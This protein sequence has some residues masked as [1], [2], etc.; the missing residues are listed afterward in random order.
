MALSP[1]LII[2]I[3][4][5]IIIIIS[6]TFSLVAVCLKALSIKQCTFSEFKFD[7]FICAAPFVQPISHWSL[8]F[9]VCVRYAR[10]GCYSFLY[11][12]HFDSDFVCMFLCCCFTS[13]SGILFFTNRAT[14]R[15][16]SIFF[17][18]NDTISITKNWG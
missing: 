15:K 2:N 5:I 10:A 14:F 7:N 11:V 16:M 3:I 13:N 8:S 1:I 18:T 12:M 17:E 4:I 6:I 9:S